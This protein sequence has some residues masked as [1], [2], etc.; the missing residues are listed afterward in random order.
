MRTRPERRL[1]ADLR[2]VQTSEAPAMVT[3]DVSQLR[4]RAEA[5]AKSGDT[6]D[7]KCALRRYGAGF[8]KWASSML[9]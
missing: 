3:M 4:A 2:V 5:G 7:H 1:A 9:L 6:A 8:A